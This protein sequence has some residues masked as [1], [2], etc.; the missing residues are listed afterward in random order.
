MPYSII[1]LLRK[2]TAGY[3]IQD[4]SRD[5][6]VFH[7]KSLSV[8][9]IASVFQVT[10]ISLHIR[11]ITIIHASINPGIDQWLFGSDSQVFAFQFDVLCSDELVIISKCTWIKIFGTKVA[12]DLQLFKDGR[13]LPVV[14]TCQVVVGNDEAG[15]LVRMITTLFEILVN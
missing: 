2:S 1:L 6:S 14:F 15:F 5:E 3:F 12:T 9:G 4:Q 7:G 13:R 8:H 10:T 11:R